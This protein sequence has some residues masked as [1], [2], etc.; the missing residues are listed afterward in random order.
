[1]ALGHG[2]EAVVEVQVLVPVDILEMRPLAP[3]DVDGP[4]IVQLVGRSDAAGEHPPG[5]PEQRFRLARALAQHGEL[6]FAELPE[7]P[8][9]ERGDHGHSA[10][11]YPRAGP[12]TAGTP[13]ANTP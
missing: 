4:R 8:A 5:P 12:L 7:A 13:R 11:S 2:A 1:M 10:G 6:S 3:D 9:I